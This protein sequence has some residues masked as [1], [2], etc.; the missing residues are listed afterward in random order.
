MRFEKYL[1]KNGSVPQRR[2]ISV[3]VTEIVAVECVA[4][5]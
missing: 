4:Y 3:I 5:H 2:N 1:E